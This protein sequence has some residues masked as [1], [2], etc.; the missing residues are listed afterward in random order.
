MEIDEILAKLD[1]Y[2][3]R[4]KM[5]IKK[6]DELS[7]KLESLLKQEEELKNLLKE[8]FGITNIETL[9]DEIKKMEEEI[10]QKSRELELSIKTIEDG[11]NK[12][13]RR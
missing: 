10:V 6:R 7:G 4:I 9:D 2:N 12:N 1:D 13:F 8:N 11:L 3:R 5:L